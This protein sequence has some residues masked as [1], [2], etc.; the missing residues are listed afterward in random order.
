LSLLSRTPNRGGARGAHQFLLCETAQDAPAAAL[1]TIEQQH[2]VS[3]IDDH[4]T[5]S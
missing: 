3:Y 5:R 1:S 2:V 4:S